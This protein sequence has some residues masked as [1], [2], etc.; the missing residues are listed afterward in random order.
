MPASSSSASSS[1]PPADSAYEA[2]ESASSKNPP[3]IAGLWAAIAMIVLYID[4]V[5]ELQKAASDQTSQLALLTRNL[6]DAENNQL[7]KDLDAINKIDPKD[8]KG[9]TVAQENYQ[10]D[11]TL[12][13]NWIATPQSMTEAWQNIVSDF[14]KTTTTGYQNLGQLIAINNNLAQILH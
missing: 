14:A 13:N 10:K 9:L 3:A 6:S 7:N 11:Q 12:Y 8:S 1:V 4:A 5:N 2:I